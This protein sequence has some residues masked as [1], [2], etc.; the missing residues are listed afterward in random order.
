MYGQDTFRTAFQTRVV[1]ENVGYGTA[2]NLVIESGQ[3]EIKT[4]N[5]VC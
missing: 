5:P 4:T 3:L 2:K 1:A